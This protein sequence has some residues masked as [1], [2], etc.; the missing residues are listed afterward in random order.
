MIASQSLRLGIAKKRTGRLGACLHRSKPHHARRFRA[1]VESLEKRMLLSAAI[2]EQP[3]LLL[4][5]TDGGQTIVKWDQPP[6]PAANPVPNQY[7]GWDEF[8]VWGSGQIA[9][10]D[11]VCTTLDPVTSITWWGS[12][13]GWSGMDFSPVAPPAFQFTIWTDVPAGVDRPWSHP[14]YV[15]WQSTCREYTTVFEGW[16]YDPRSSSYEAMFRFDQSLPQSDWFYQQAGQ[17]IYWLSIAAVYPD[18]AIPVHPF[19]WAT[20]PRMDSLAPDDAVQILLPTAPQIGMPFVEGHPLEFPPE[21]SWDLCFELGTRKPSVVKWEQPPEPRLP[22]LHAHDYQDVQVHSIT[23]AD[24]WVCQ[25]GD[26]TDLHWWGNYEVDE[27]GNEIRGSGIQYFHLS[28]HA[29]AINQPWGLPGKE[30]WA[31]DVPFA[32]VGETFTGIP[33][34]EGSGIYYYTFDLPVPFPQVQG[35]TY[36][37]DISAHSNLPSRPAQWR[38]QEAGRTNPPTLSPAAQRL[39]AGPWQ[40]ISWVGPK[41]SKMAFQITSG[42]GIQETKW[43][44]LPVPYFSQD[45]FFHGW[46]EPSVYGQ[47]QIVADDWVCVTRD[48]VTRIEWWGS[49]LGW[50]RSGPPEILPVGFHL[51][52]WTDVPVGVSNFSHPGK[53]LREWNVEGYNWEFVGWEVDPRNPT[54]APEAVYHFWVDLPESQWFWQPGDQQIFWLNVAAKYPQAMVPLNPF[55]WLT[56]PRSGQ[57]PAPDDAVRIFNPTSP[58]LS[59]PVQGDSTLFPLPNGQ[60][61]STGEAL[62]LQGPMVMLRNMRMTPSPGAPTIVLPPDGDTRRVDSFF[63]VF[64]ETSTDGGGS[65]FPTT[66]LGCPTSLSIR[67]ILGPATEEVYQTEILGM[68]IWGGA[69]PGLMLRESPQLPSTGQHKRQAVGDGGGGGYRVD[70]FFDVFTELSSD[71]GQT[72]VPSVTPPLHLELAGPAGEYVFGEPIFWPEPTMSWDTAFRLVSSARDMDWGDA[73]DKPFPTLASNNGARH[74]IVPGCHLGALVDAEPDG[75]PTVL[76]DGDDINSPTGLDDED[77]VVFTSAIVPGQVTTLDVTASLPGFLWAWIDFNGNGSWAEADELVFAGLPLVPGVNHLS[78]PVPPAAVGDTYTYARF[79]FTTSTAPLSYTGLAPDG[80]VED[81][82]AFV[83]RPIPGDVKWVQWPDLTPNGIDIKV[84]QLVTVADDWLCTDTSLLTDVHLWGSWLGDRKGIIDSIELTVYADDPIGPGGTDPKNEFSKPDVQALWRAVFAKG[85][86]SESLYAEIPEPGEYWWDPRIRQAIPGADR[87]I[88]RIDIPIEP[89]EAFKQL[90]KPDSPVI[91]WLQVRVKT[92][93]G[94]F[95]WKTRRWPDHFMDD[96]TWDA[97]SELPRNW[98]EL[99]Y[100]FGHPYYQSPQPSID[101]AFALTFQTVQDLDWG[102]APEDPAGAWGYPTLAI[103]NGARHAIRSGFFLGQTIDAELD[104]QPS[105]SAVDDDLNGV[106][107]EDGVV[108]LDPLIPGEIVRV[109]VTASMAGGFLNAWVDFDGNS[110][111]ADPGEQIFTAMPLNPGVNHL[112]FVVPISAAL[113][114]EHRAR[115]AYSRFRFS[116]LAHLPYEGYAPDGEVEDYM[117]WI[118]ALDFGDAPDSPGTLGYRTLRANDGARHLL[119]TTRNPTFGTLQ[120]TDADPDGQPH[121]QALGDDLEMDDESGLVNAWLPMHGNSY[122]TADVRNIEA[123]GANAWV[124]IWL[125]V[126]GNGKWDHPGEMV[127]NTLVTTDGEHRF[128]FVMPAGA[129]AGM[130]FLRMRISTLGGLMP[131]GFADDG[132]VEDHQVVII[133]M[134]WG[135]APDPTYPTLAASNG[136]SHWVHHDDAKRLHLGQ[137]VDTE[138]DGQPSLLADGDDLS[139]IMMDDEDGVIFTSPLVPGKT[140][141]VDVTATIGPDFAGMAALSSW[142]DFDRNGVWDDTD[143][144]H[145]MTPIVAGVNHLTIPVPDW[146]QPGATYAR[147][148]IKVANPGAHPSP[149]GYGGVGEV[150]DYRITIEP[151]L[152]FGDAPDGLTILGYPTLAIHNGARHVIQQGLYLGYSVDAE[153]DGQ[154]SPLADGDDK[155]PPLGP[156][157]EDGVVFT[158]L[159]VPGNIAK[160]DVIASARGK[161]DAFVDFNADNDWADAGEK[162]FN[163]VDLVPGLNHLTFSVPASATISKTYA[164]F[165]FSTAG[166]LNYDGLAR[167]GEVEDYLVAIERGATITGAKF[168]DRNFDRARQASEPGLSGWTIFLDQNHNGTLDPTER[169]TITAP[170]G[171]YLFDFLL[172]GSYRVAEVLKS[173]WTQTSPATGYYDLT[174]GPSDV[175]SGYN[176]GNFP[177]TIAGAD[178][179]DTIYVRLDAT[180]TQIEIFINVAPGPSPTYTCPKNP[181]FAITF[182]TLG[183]NDLLTVDLVNGQPIPAAGMFYNGGSQTSLPGDQLAFKGTPIS[184]GTY[185][186]NATTPGDG[187]VLTDGAYTLTFTGLEPI[188]VSTFVKFTIVTPNPN[189]ALT[190]DKPAAT[191]NRVSGTSGGVAFENVTLSLVDEL[192]L[193]L[194]TND[195]G[196]GNDTVVSLDGSAT[197]IGLLS[198]N[199]GTGTNLARFDGGTTNLNTNLGIGGVKLEVRAAGNAIVNFHASQFL[200]ALTA[201]KKGRINLAA[202]G[203][204]V[205]DTQSLVISDAGIVDLFNNNMIVR[206]GDRD[207]IGGWIRSARNNGAWDGNGLTSSTAAST[208]YTGLAAILNDQGDGTKVLDLFAGQTVNNTDMLIKYTW[209]GDANLDERIDADDYFL[210]DSG[211]IMQSKGYRNGDFNYDG[212]IDADDYFM[213]DSAFIGQT[214]PL[215]APRENPSAVAEVAIQ[216][217]AKKTDMKGI[218]TQL[219]STQPVL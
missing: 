28:I 55:G 48:P 160:V 119:S 112:T 82:R 10:D 135:D 208:K 196:A 38:W 90:G 65:W 32:M 215:A 19:G 134:D 183:G 219:F 165:R 56:R 193:D 30:L 106:D 201:V 136:A 75:Q 47:A 210:I 195:A 207:T 76:A 185:L 93:E 94:E 37:F 89:G 153:V 199:A 173:G 14:G 131:W 50:T 204:R 107:D 182:N 52:L 117:D 7:L 85:R 67:R 11:W 73:P 21:V 162:I 5:G 161:L 145:S 191:T 167:D 66:S 172:P 72:W 176:F 51:G 84:D 43:S 102:D 155:N 62:F 143:I 177:T 189:D 23:L 178:N 127:V 42:G 109:D 45:L 142:F 188:T 152:D 156:D 216:Q 57:S 214:G 111:W 212:T 68:S 71:G 61:S 59:G 95:G 122:I 80:E 129:A 158:T 64:F 116:S 99:H 202:H 169:S 123:A 181:P 81:Y 40:S 108:F 1:P 168:E 115:G 120:P 104:G 174:V 69:L 113:P 203:D 36:W 157:D 151:Y 98:K 149:E 148:R 26:V 110:S 39:D 97:G 74:V 126:N 144:V 124:Q 141:T 163:S 206:N 12:A 217:K 15:I 22:G 186:P 101:M 44:Q 170:D 77:G 25:G 166:G 137:I 130:T 128:N 33:N 198:I 34:P 53:L 88:W 17:G 190:I 83:Q 213:I 139:I 194:A 92:A 41:Y 31:M 2:A 60:Y 171:S 164:R 49:F 180:R 125:D 209:D 4:A 218:L 63:D 118:R 20:K 86:F 103:H 78:L 132:E 79:R 140:A 187:R 70:S 29:N 35:Q 87:Q 9:A 46:D 18:G 8:S 13:I 6:M 133:A 91:Y 54:A 192:V 27:H 159:L 200:A 58:S 175:A 3:D 205:I 211:Y 24:D 16:E 96:A 105:F 154:P 114:N 150:E 179:A 197:T 138:P 121:P 147:F 184:A 100:P 146:A